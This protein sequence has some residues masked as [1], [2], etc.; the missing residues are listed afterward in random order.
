MER[1]VGPDREAIAQAP[2]ETNKQ[3]NK[4]HRSRASPDTR[5][6]G[7]PGAPRPRLRLGTSPLVARSTHV[8]ALNLCTPGVVLAAGSASLQPQ[9]RGP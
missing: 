1:E 8:P 5:L 2:K 3:T 4:T 6:P 9:P 7:P